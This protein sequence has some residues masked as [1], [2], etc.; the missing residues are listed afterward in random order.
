[1]LAPRPGGMFI[2]YR[3]SKACVAIM[4]KCIELHCAKASPIARFR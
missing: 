1:M 3:A 4:T 2:A